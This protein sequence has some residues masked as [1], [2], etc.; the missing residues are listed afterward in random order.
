[1]ASNSGK[2][3]KTP[4]LTGWSLF[5]AVADDLIFPQRPCVYVVY[6][7]GVLTY[8]GQTINLRERM[9]R[10]AI[11]WGYRP[12]LITPWGRAERAIV[13]AGW[14][15]KYGDWAMRELRLIKRLRPTGNVC[16]YTGRNRSKMVA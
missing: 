15:R 8:I 2:S 6:L 10:H 4:S 16:A 3:A 14:P 5:D 1:M 7:D 9:Q 11:R 12:L 13:K